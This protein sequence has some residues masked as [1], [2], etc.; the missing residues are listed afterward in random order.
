MSTPANL[1]QIHK[2]LG[3]KG[4]LCLEENLDANKIAIIKH[5]LPGSTIY[6]ADIYKED[7]VQLLIV[8]GSVAY[9]KSVSKLTLEH[10]GLREAGVSGFIK[11]QVTGESLVMTEVKGT[12]NIRLTPNANPL[13]AVLYENTKLCL[14]NTN[15][16]YLS[17]LLGS[18]EIAP[19]QKMKTVLP[20]SYSEIKLQRALV[21][22][23][24]SDYYE[25][26]ITPGN[27]IEVEANEVV[28]WTGDINLEEYKDANGE[29]NLIRFAGIGNLYLSLS[30]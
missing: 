4:E 13:K 23:E 9:L 17:A 10:Y 18:F 25:I 24:S 11:S 3:S 14:P 7:S 8:A 30:I 5:E 26:P 15:I 21:L 28:F 6:V 2:G 22:M 29:A 27:P 12:G 1:I 20:I 16:T 19:P